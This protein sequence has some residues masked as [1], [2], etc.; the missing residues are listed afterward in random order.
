MEEQRIYTSTELA[1]MLDISPHTLRKYEKDYEL[2][3]NRNK[4]GARE[5]GENEVLIFKLIIEFKKQ[6]ATKSRIKEELAK[7]QCHNEHLKDR[8]ENMREVAVTT[9][10]VSDPVVIKTEIINAITEKIESKLESKFEQMLLD[11]Q[12]VIVNRILEQ[13]RQE[14]DK[15]ISYIEKTRQEEKEKKF[16]L[17]RQFKKAIKLIKSYKI[18]IKRTDI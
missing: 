18:E 3:I 11:Q 6:G 9:S 16:N 5:Y 12:E 10:S 7:S 4:K 8:I 2:M 13:Q 14:N 15:L 1:E 17:K